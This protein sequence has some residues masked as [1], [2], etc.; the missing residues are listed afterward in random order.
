VKVFR[1]DG[2]LKPAS[3]LS[4][5]LVAFL[6]FINS[7]GNSFSSVTATRNSQQFLVENVMELFRN[8]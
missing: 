6:C 2:Y 7:M 4:G 8:L 5:T 3:A 1:E